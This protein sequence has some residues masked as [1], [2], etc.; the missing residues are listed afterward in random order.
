M[1]IDVTGTVCLDSTMIRRIQSLTAESMVE[2]TDGLW[3]ESGEDFL[4]WLD[5]NNPTISEIG[6]TLVSSYPFYSFSA[7]IEVSTIV[8]AC[9]PV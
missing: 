6:G 1:M 9:Y 5:E 3:K 7:L 2:L 4:D 8:R